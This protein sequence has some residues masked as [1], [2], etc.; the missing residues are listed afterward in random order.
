L[1]DSA[2]FKLKLVEE[3]LP[4][5]VVLVLLELLFPLFLTLRILGRHPC[6]QLS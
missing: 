6:I 4:L 5:V 3:Q 1:K 2:R